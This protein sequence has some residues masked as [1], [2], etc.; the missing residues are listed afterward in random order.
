MNRHGMI[1]RLLCAAVFLLFSSCA[2]SPD[3][4]IDMMY[5]MAYDHDSGE[6]MDVSVFIDGNE[7]GKTDIYG[8][9]TYP[10]TEERTAVIRAEKAGYE[11][12]EFNAAV[13]SG[14]VLYF[15]MGS[16]SWY[17]AKAERLLD[18]DNTYEALK[19]IDIALR[20]Q[21]RKDWLF[22]REVISGRLKDES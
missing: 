7:I 15:K 2:S 6:I 9:L 12:V 17:A 22:L 19:M 3:E 4:K 18:E 13:R 14:T 8:R 1:L 11:S 16:G 20:I 5:V 21:E 10:C